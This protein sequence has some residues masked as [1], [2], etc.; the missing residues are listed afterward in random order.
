VPNGVP[1]MCR[2]RRARLRR[3]VGTRAGLGRCPL[4]CCWPSGADP[5]PANR[6]FRHVRP[7]SR[8]RLS[9]VAPTPARAEDRRGTVRLASSGDGGG[10]QSSEEIHSAVLRA[11][12]GRVPGVAV[13][14]RL[15]RG[16]GGVDTVFGGF[17]RVSLVEATSCLET[18]GARHGVDT[19]SATSSRLPS[20]ST[21]S[22]RPRP[23]PGDRARRDTRAMSPN[24]CS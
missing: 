4:G 6:A 1:L 21:K 12:V 15:R 2:G 7:R 8:T 18:V 10:A 16:L 9:R 17:E 23:P 13:R 5:C 14:C 3:P 22:T 24:H 20:K 11:H 19:A